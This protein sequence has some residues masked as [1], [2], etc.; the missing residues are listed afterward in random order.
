MTLLSLLLRF[1]SCSVVEF[2]AACLDSEK[3]G[4]YFLAAFYTLSCEKLKLEQCHSNRTYF[5]L[6]FDIHAI[7]TRLN[8]CK[9]RQTQ[10]E[11]ALLQ[12]VPPSDILTLKDR[13]HNRGT[14]KGHLDL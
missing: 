9:H 10:H 6:T 14:P 7:S 11:F 3:A 13:S 12:M 4:T 2:H 8:L 1:F 5:N